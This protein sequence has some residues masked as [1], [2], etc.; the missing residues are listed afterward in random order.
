MYFRHRPSD[1]LL[2]CAFGAALITVA[3]GQS[4]A[5]SA[6][7][8]PS[9][10]WVF[11]GAVR[12]AATLHPVVNARVTVP[13]MVA[14]ITTTTD[15]AGRFR[16]E[17]AYPRLTTPTNVQ[18][19]ANG[20]LPENQSADLNCSEMVAPVGETAHCRQSLDFELRQADP[21]FAGPSPSCAVSGTVV[22][23]QN[24]PVDKAML[25]IPGTV[26]T[27]LTDAQGRFTIPDVPAGLRMIVARNLGSWD[28]EQIMLVSCDQTRSSATIRLRLMPAVIW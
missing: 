8:T 22:Q 21:L 10:V 13:L 28:V 18:V 27:A 4:F 3:A 14:A 16:I 24:R 19:Y 5:Q 25:S 23:Y 15:S 26:L 7:P 9:P 6:T 20:Y 17:R 2:S 11:S 12:D 1:I